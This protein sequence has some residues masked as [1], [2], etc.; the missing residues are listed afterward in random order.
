MPTMQRRSSFC[1]FIC[2]ALAAAALS[3]CASDDST[4]RLLVAPNKYVLYN[5]PE[6]SRE[7]LLKQ[8]RQKEL[9]DLINKDGA[10]AGARM[11]SGFTYD[12]EYLSVR[13]EI[14]DLHATAADKNCTDLPAADAVK[15]DETH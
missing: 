8:T 7:L 11:V 10:S 9:R 14:N 15:I 12:P 5:C 1:L 4:A 6:I 2:A 13:G 3:G